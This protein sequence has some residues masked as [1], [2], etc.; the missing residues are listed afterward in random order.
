MP[1]GRG[2]EGEGGGDVV[3]DGWGEEEDD[4]AEVLRV[5]NVLCVHVRACVCVCVQETWCMYVYVCVCMCVYVCVCMHLSACVRAC[6][7]VHTYTYT[8]A[9]MHASIHTQESCIIQVTYA[10]RA[11]PKSCLLLL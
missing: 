1:A 2:G 11:R 6:M 7:H 8:R 5:S 10:R 9:C 4:L 3:G